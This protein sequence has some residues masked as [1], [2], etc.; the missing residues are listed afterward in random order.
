MAW[1]L[2]DE[3][4][5]ERSLTGAELDAVRELALS[6]G[7]P[8]PLPGTIAAVT[9]TVRGYVNAHKPNNL[10]AGMTIPDELESAAISLIRYHLCT[11]L[12]NALLDEDR[13]EEYRNAIALL[14]DV[15]AG[16]FDIVQPEDIT[17]E[18]TNTTKFEVAKSRKR[19]ATRSQL[20]GLI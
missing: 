7:Q 3:S 16:R 14:R 2:L 12:P 19:V 18:P 8:D 17:D 5:V 11:R 9:K 20:D 10:G 15:A 6:E 1:I 4:K 13:R